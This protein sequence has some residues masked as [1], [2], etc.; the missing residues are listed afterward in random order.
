LLTFP[1]AVA[2]IATATGREIRYI[3]VSLEDYAAGAVDHGTPA[4]LVEFLTYLF[5]DVL[6]N[7]PYVTDGVQRALGR[8]PRDFADY[9][10][11]TAASGVWTPSAEA[12]R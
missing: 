2:E 4:E 11:E 12:D 7:R 8:P 9:A 10:A 1:D 5:G 3:P 6:G